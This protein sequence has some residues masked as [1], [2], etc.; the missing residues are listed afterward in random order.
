VPG[1]TL[2]TVTVSADDIDGDFLGYEWRAT[3]G[4]ALNTDAPQT[5]WLLP[6]GR[7]L[8][9]IYVLVHDSFGGYTEKQLA[10]STD[11]DVVPEFRTFLPVITGPTVSHPPVILPSD[12]VPANDQFLTYAALARYDLAP[13]D[14]FDMGGP[15]DNRFSACT[16]YRDIGAVSGCKSDGTPIGKQL[17]FDVWKQIWGFGVSDKEVSA[18]YANLAD[19]NLQRDMHTISAIGPRPGGGSGT[20]VAS[21]VCNYP[22]PEADTTL[23]NVRLGNNLVACVAFEYSVT[24]SPTSSLPYNGGQPF[25]KFYIFGPTGDLLLSVNLDGR[26]EK[27]VPGA[28]AACHGGSGYSGQYALPGESETPALNAQFIPYDLDN[29]RFSSVAG[30]RRQDQETSFWALNQAVL[31]TQPSTATQELIQGWYP[32]SS[33]LFNGNFIP[34]GWTG[35]E[36]LYDNVVKPACRM[37]H[38]TLDPDVS[39]NTYPAFARWKN[40]IWVRVCGSNSQ[41]RYS[42]AMPNARQTFDQFWTNAS[43][44]APPGANQVG[45]LLSFLMAEGVTDQFGNPV[46]ACVLPDW[47]P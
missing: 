28:C 32:V 46:T 1:G 44:S 26:G 33:S 20:D 39:F 19:L 12:H 13:G 9:F 7:G 16:Y 36:N 18:K 2:V 24:N 27:F 23:S 41:G 35:H 14:R 40:E 11:G 21:Y 4:I 5:T 3:D 6:K 34:T 42:Y 17:T 38:S 10:L 15:L 37:C 45:T 8:H 47:L 30:F 25:T 31:T 29:Y 43:P 22:N